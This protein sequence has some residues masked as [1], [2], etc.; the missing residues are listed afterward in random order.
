MLL[1]HAEVSLNFLIQSAVAAVAATNDT[2]MV[3]ANQR[4]TLSSNGSNGE[5]RSPNSSDNSDDNSDDKSEKCDDI[6]RDF[7]RNVCKRG[8]R[9]KYRH[10]EPPEAREL[11]KQAEFTFCH[12]F[13]NSGCRRAHCK[14]IHCSR[15]EEE[16]YKQ[17]GQLPV[18]LQQAAALGIGVIPNE[19]PLLKGE[20]PICKD[21]LK[22][23][24]K[25][26]GR[27]KYRHLSGTQYEY[28]VRTS[29]GS[30]PV[31]SGGL[32][33]AVGPAGAVQPAPNQ[34][35]L[36]TAVP[37]PTNTAQPPPPP[38]THNNRFEPATYND[39][40][41]EQYNSYESVIPAKRKKLDFDD[42]SLNQISTFHLP[43][44]CVPPPPLRFCGATDVRLLEEENMMLRRKV[45]ELKKQVSD[46]AATNE[47]LLEQ[48]ARY[49]SANRNNSATTAS[50]LPIVT[51]SQLAMVTPTITTTVTPTLG[52]P[53]MAAMPQG[54]MNSL[55]TTLTPITTTLNPITT[56]LASTLNP[57]STTLN[58][59]APDSL[60][61]SLSAQITTLPQLTL[62]AN[63]ELLVSQGTLQ[64]GPPQLQRHPGELPQPPS[65]NAPP[66]PVSINPSSIVPVSIGVETL[67]PHGGISSVS[68]T[69]ST[70][71]HSNVSLPQSSHPGPLLSMPSTSMISY[72]IMS[73]AQLP[74][75]SLNSLATLN[76]LNTINTSLG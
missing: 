31:V 49:R 37:P 69:Q 1:P 60:S 33:P 40:A 39:D 27:C 9:C 17:T 3:M 18:R 61:A 43:A 55:N 16:Y 23:E 72:P 19:A 76:S 22:G 11:G 15:E 50:S 46:L 64:A 25:R 48:N 45:E 4:W 70:L 42:I 66:P 29:E 30:T 34:P 38:P 75:N 65:M 21:Y 52:R 32:R 36:T 71:H 26:G 44:T 68:L 51:V 6:C 59:L 28:E 24:C 57:L 56:S 53:M 41:Y 63:S 14:F 58:H 13:Q 73:H 47:V 35:N 8:K 5:E 67:A 2:L 12:D 74:T 20:V 7:L 54:L 62:N 10:P